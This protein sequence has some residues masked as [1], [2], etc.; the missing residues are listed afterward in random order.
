V[1]LQNKTMSQAAQHEFVRRVYSARLESVSN[2]QRIDFS[3][4]HALRHADTGTDAYSIFNRVQE[5]LIRG[6]IQ[7]VYTRHTKN[8]QGEVIDSRLVSSTTRKIAS[9][10]A[11][12]KLNQLVYD[13]AMEL[14]A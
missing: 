11:Q 12:V 13:T 4:P 14:A 8:D 9:V 3:L 7:Y 2:I 5:K 6:G 1:A 10:T